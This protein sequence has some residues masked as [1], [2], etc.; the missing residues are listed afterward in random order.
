MS[1]LKIQQLQYKFNVCVMKQGRSGDNWFMSRMA[2]FQAKDGRVLIV[3]GFESMLR[4]DFPQN[5]NITEIENL[6]GPK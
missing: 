5:I 2:V 6:V 3:S 1:V 4:T